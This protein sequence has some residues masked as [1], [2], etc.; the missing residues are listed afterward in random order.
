MLQL[1]LEKFHNSFD[2]YKHDQT[3]LKRVRNESSGSH[4]SL[5]LGLFRLKTNQNDLGQNGK[6][7]IVLQH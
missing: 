2:V 6:V 7:E 5:K 4:M 3:V 1:S